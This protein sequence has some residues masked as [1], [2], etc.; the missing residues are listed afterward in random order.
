MTGWS[1]VEEARGT[2]THL[3]TSQP[4]AFTEPRLRAGIGVDRHSDHGQLYFSGLFKL[5]PPHLFF[6]LYEEPPSPDIFN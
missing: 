1:G 3:Q 4:P 6:C 5:E 2:C